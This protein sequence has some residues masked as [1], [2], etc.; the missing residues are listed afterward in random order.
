MPQDLP[1][2][3]TVLPRISALVRSDATGQLTIDGVSQAISATDD[4]GVRQEIVARVVAS[5][6]LA[7]RALHVLITDDDGEWPLL[8]HV[9]GQIEADGTVARTPATGAAA[10]A[11]TPAPPLSRRAARE[12]AAAASA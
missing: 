1:T 6:E 5:A 9:D 8:V 3:P 12:A 2:P 10:A 7:G 4:A 11:H